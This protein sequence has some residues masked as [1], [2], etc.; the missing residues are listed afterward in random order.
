MWIDHLSEKTIRK[1]D[2]DLNK[3]RGAN[4]FESDVRR[5]LGIF[6]FLRFV[7]MRKIERR[8]WADRLPHID[9]ERGRCWLRRS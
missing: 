6:G 4:F 2:E 9:S 5:Y 8:G 1:I 7:V 3:R